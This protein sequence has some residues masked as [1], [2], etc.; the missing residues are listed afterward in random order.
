MSGTCYMSMVPIP[1]ISQRHSQSSGKVRQEVMLSMHQSKAKAA[2]T[3]DTL[4]GD[5][6]VRGRAQGGVT[7]AQKQDTRK[8]NDATHAQQE[9]GIHVILT[10]T[11][12]TC[13]RAV[14]LTLTIYSHL[15]SPTLPIKL[16]VQLD[17][18]IKLSVYRTS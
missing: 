3:S 9:Q 13:I 2:P 14:R 11:T 8:W 4:V 5:S 6:E 16:R 15:P 17:I 1:L 12:H 10:L 7:V 18:G